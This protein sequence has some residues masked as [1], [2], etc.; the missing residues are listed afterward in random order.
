MEAMFAE[1]GKFF[2]THSRFIIG[3]IVNII[4]ISVFLRVNRCFYP[5]SLKHV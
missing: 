2:M 1:L 3:V 4:I 5:L